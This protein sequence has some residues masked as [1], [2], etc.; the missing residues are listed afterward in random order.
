MSRNFGAFVISAAVVP[1]LV[2]GCVSG[3]GGP[4]LPVSQVV[5][6]QR[7]AR[8]AFVNSAAIAHA[9]KLI[10]VSDDEDE[11]VIV[12]N[13]SGQPLA[14]LSGFGY[15]QG[16]AN[17][18]KGDLYVADQTKSRIRIYSPGFKS[19]PKT[20]RDPG[21]YPV[22]LDSFGSGK[23]LAVVNQYTTS[24]GPGSV[25]MYVNGVEGATITNP[26]IDQ[27]SFDAFD[28]KGNLYVTFAPNGSSCPCIGEIAD[29]T[30]GGATL[31][32]LTTA[33]SISPYGI[34]VTAS[35]QI[36]VF[37]QGSNTIYTYNP[38]VGGSLGSPVARTVLGG[39][40]L[41][42]PAQ[43][44]FTKDM[45]DFYVANNSDN[46]SLYEYRYPAGGGPVSSISVGG[47]PFGVAL[48]PKERP[49]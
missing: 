33:N 20:L 9:T 36:A 13:P 43:F 21:Q 4:A 45:K 44:A 5:T 42:G 29:A 30:K 18:T 48:F 17:D 49:R 23:Y 24:Y 11:A 38:P 1:F 7:V 31:A 47:L 3:G 15:P 39:T 46:N 19:K 35:G 12:Y 34:Q 10:V 41:N 32:T 25:T 22:A 28:A 2:G 8:A 37:D 14:V 40:F 6:A 16:L 26:A 27:A